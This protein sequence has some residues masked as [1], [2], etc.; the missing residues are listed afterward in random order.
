LEGNGEGECVRIIGKMVR[1]MESRRGG[2][3]WQ[4]HKEDNERDGK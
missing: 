4:D 2:K 1:E 3:I